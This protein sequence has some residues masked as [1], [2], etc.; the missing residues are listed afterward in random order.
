VSYPG[1]GGY[2]PD[3]DGRKRPKYKLAAG[4]Q[5]VFWGNPYPDQFGHGLLLPMSTSLY[6]SAGK[7]LGVVGAD[8]TFHVIAGELLDLPGY[9]DV[10]DEYLVDDQGRVVVH[11]ATRAGKTVERGGVDARTV[12]DLDADNRPVELAALPLPDVVA[13]IRAGRSSGVGSSGGRVLAYQRLSALGWYYV[14]D[15]TEPQLLAAAR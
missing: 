3:Y 7:L 2:P 10:E 5:G 12:R 15:V 8:S 14:V 13:A 4:K 11:A 6:D 1:L 9:P